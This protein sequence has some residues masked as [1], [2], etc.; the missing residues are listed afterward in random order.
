MSRRRLVRDPGV[1][2]AIGKAV[3]GLISAELEF[4]Y[5]RVADWPVAFFLAQ[6][7]QRAAVSF[8]YGDFV[9]RRLGLGPQNH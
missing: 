6:L 7:K 2:F 9:G 4:H 5:A 1:A 8:V 3:N